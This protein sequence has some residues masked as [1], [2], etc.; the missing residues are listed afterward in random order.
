MSF[1]SVQACLFD[2]DGLLLDTESIYT[3]VTQSIIGPLGHQYH[4]GLKSNM[5]G[6]PAIESATYLVETLELP[7]SPEEYLEQRSVKLLEFM[8]TCKPLPGARELIEHLHS[9]GIPIA[10]ATSSSLSLFETKTM[11]HKDWFS[12]FDTVVTPDSERV[13]KGKPAPDIFLEAARQLNVSAEKA[14][15]FEDAPSGLQAGISAG[16]QVVAVPDPN[17]DK[18]RYQQATVVLDSLVDFSPQDFG[19]PPF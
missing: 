12:L 19:L 13:V 18:D 14:L 8:P 11:H 1:E 16:M 9:N 3:E 15:V 10:V 2:M 5:I 6:R 7:F 17:M 4:W